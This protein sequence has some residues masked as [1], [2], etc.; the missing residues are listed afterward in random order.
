MDPIA[1]EIKQI[2]SSLKTLKC[3]LTLIHREKGASFSKENVRTMDQ[4]DLFM[5]YTKRLEVLRNTQNCLDTAPGSD[6]NP[7]AAA[8]PVLAAA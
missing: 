7:A 6:P 1:R 3:V 5:R 2:T 4:N 8:A